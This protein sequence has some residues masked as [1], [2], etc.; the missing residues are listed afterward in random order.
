MQ[1][2]QSD[3]ARQLS[4]LISAM[5]KQWQ[6]E[7]GELG[8]ALTEAALRGAQNLLSASH[9]GAIAGMLA[10][11]PIEHH[12]GMDWVAANPWAQ[13][14]LSHIAQTVGPPQHGAETVRHP[15]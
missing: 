11:A 8:A 1:N 12:V 5:Q 3:Q 13:P 15:H 14:Y 2:R 9:S 10:S 6:Q 4:K 7:L